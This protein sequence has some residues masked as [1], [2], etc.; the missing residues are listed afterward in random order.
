VTVNSRTHSPSG[1]GNG[2]PARRR[3]VTPSSLRDPRE[4]H[5]RG[6]SHDDA[7]A[8]CTAHAAR[9]PRDRDPKHLGATIDEGPHRAPASAGAPSTASEAP[10]GE[11][12]RKTGE[13]GQVARHAPRLRTAR[14]RFGLARRRTSRTRPPASAGR[15]RPEG[16]ST[17][18]PEQ[19]PSGGTLR[20]TRKVLGHQRSHQ[21]SLRARK[22]TSEKTRQDH[23]ATMTQ[24]ATGCGTWRR[25]SGRHSFG[26]RCRSGRRRSNASRATCRARRQ[27]RRW[28]GQGRTDLRA[29]Q[30]PFRPPRGKEWG[31][32]RQASA[33]RHRR[34][35]T[36]QLNGRA[37]ARPGCTEKVLRHLARW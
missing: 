24:T 25:P 11:H 9:Q 3:T 27:P 26:S 6:A 7:E 16:Q 17:D 22:V 15:G 8:G 31:P 18:E 23:H 5:P 19:T 30:R 14:Q 36:P 34:P 4:T 2:G 21:K 1:D 13:P 33:S 37:S 20:K 28:S 35:R 32:A 29:A 10:P 12:E